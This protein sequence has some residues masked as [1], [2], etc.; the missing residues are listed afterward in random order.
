MISNSTSLVQIEVGFDDD[1]TPSFLKNKIAE[2][3]QMAEVTH[4]G[5]GLGVMF[6]HFQDHKRTDNHL[7]VKRL[8]GSSHKP[9]YTVKRSLSSL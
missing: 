2:V 3:E 7:K 9:I 4:T 1:F 6:D 8:S 5:K